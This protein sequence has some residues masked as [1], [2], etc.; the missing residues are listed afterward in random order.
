VEANRLLADIEDLLRR[1]LGPALDLEMVLADGL[2]PTLCDPNQLE[3]A[4][5]NLV[6]NARDAMPDGGRLTIETANAILDDAYA[7]TQGERSGPGSISRSASPTP[8]SAWSRTSLPGHSIPSSR[9]SPPG[10]AQVSAC[11]CCTASSSNRTAMCG[12]FRAG[13]RHNVQ[14]VLA[15]IPRAER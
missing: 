4:I 7:R 2:W 11:R 5:L 10:R 8:A 1:T 13:P 14:A 6:I 3:A 15:A 9:Q 12:L